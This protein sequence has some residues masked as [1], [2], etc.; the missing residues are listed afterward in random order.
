MITLIAVAALGV[1]C[2]LLE[3]INLRKIIVPI[4]VVGLLATLGYSWYSFSGDQSFYNNMIVTNKFIY[5]LDDF[6]S[7]NGK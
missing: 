3:I 4:T 2:L 5:C 1:L 6:F 7:C